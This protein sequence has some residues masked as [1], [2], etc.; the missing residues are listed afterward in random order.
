MVA[1]AIADAVASDHWDK[2]GN[3][4][5]IPNPKKIVVGFDTRFLSDRYAGEMARVLSANG[6]T[7]MLTQADAPT[8]AI[9]YSVKHHNAIAAV[10]VTASHNAPRYNGVKL[11]AAFGGSALPE[12]CRRVEVYINDNEQRA[13]GP[14]LMDFNKAREIGLIE[15]FNPLPDY[16]DHLRTLIDT[17]IIADEPQR[18]VV[19]SMYGSGRGVVKAFLQVRWLKSAVK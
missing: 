13:R 19:D 5:P 2:S 12:Q 4:G 10:V 3:G 14:N 15:K 9:S 11:K 18:L 17:N 7:V 16:F 6:F 1:Q 8:P